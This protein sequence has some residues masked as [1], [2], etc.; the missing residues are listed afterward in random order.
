[1]KQEH[2]PSLAPLIVSSKSTLQQSEES[3]E[4]TMEEFK[5]KVS[6]RFVAIS[7]LGSMLMAFAMGRAAR[8]FLIDGP[9]SSMLA[10]LEQRKQ[11]WSS[12]R[13]N[14][15]AF[16]TLDGHSV[17]HTRYSSKNFDTARSVAVSSWLATNCD[18][19]MFE[20][21]DDRVAFDD[22]NDSEVCRRHTSFDLQDDS[23]QYQV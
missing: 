12:H 14:D 8:V 11:V 16:F 3:R 10:A 22:L 15:P 19:Q 9:R 17:P 20:R 6:R 21:G 5:V 2:R 13:P 7:L 4:E 18:T 1:M 23:H